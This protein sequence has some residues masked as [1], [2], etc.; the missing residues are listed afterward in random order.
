[1]GLF[2]KKKKD[3]ITIDVKPLIKWQGGSGEGCL[4]SDRITKEGFKVGYMYR[5]EPDENFPDSGWRFFAGNEDDKYSNDPNN[6]HI[7]A[8]NT[9]C[10]YDPDII[11]YVNATYGTAFIRID[12]RSFAVDD[13]TQEVFLKKQTGYSLYIDECFLRINIL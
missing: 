2:K 7:F 10:N 13:G 3:F 9:V 5:E 1:M 11:P 8:I 12:E 4:V 6:I